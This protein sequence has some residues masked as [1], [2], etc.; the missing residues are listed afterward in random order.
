ML[1]L[2]DS[3]LQFAFVDMLIFFKCIIIF[4]YICLI[5]DCCNSPQLRL[6]RQDFPNNRWWT[7][8]PWFHDMIP[9]FHVLNEYYQPNIPK[10]HDNC[11][12]K[13]HQIDIKYQHV[14]S[15]E[16]NT[17]KPAVKNPSTRIENYGDF[18]V[19][20]LHALIRESECRA[21]TTTRRGNRVSGEAA[22]VLFFLT[23]KEPRAISY[24]LPE[25]IWN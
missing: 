1:F 13:H 22:G 11:S 7:T 23:S 8:L 15:Q 20:P 16:T 2:F 9:W 18:C 19:L 5:C 10:T 12:K 4:L 24:T 17:T 3:H 14:F 6:N 21:T 25:T